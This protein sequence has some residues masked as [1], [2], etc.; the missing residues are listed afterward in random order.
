MTKTQVQREK[1]RGLARLVV[2]LPKEEMMRLKMHAV[3]KDTSMNDLAW[4][5]INKYL[6]SIES[7]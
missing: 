2:L 6:R 4:A 3:K 7:Q 5:A 1:E